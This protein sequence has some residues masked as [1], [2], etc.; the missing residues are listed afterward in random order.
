MTTQ[1]RYC[2]VL[3][4]SYLGN[5]PKYC[6]NNSVI[7]TASSKA[8]ILE[9]LDCW[10]HVVYLKGDLDVEYAAYAIYETVVE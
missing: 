4:K 1:I 9:K 5:E 2:L 7:I 10:L 8:L 3:V 6:K